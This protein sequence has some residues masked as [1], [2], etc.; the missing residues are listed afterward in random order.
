MG[1]EADIGI[2]EILGYLAAD[3]RTTGIL[4]YLESLSCGRAFVSSARAAARIKL[5]IGLKPRQRPIFQRTQEPLIDQEAVYDAVFSRT[6]LLRVHDAAEWF[7]PLSDSAA[8]D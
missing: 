6:G 5:I 2:D 7:A 4:L 3:G 1:D 8:H